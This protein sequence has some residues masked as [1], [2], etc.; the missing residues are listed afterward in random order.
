MNFLNFNF[1]THSE[2][3]AQEEKER[4][5]EWKNKRMKEWKHKYRNVKEG[6]TIRMLS[7]TFEKHN[8]ISQINWNFFLFLLLFLQL[9]EGMEF[10]DILFG[11]FGNYFY[12][13]YIFFTNLMYSIKY[14][15][16]GWE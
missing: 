3:K 11:Q 9:E 6:K 2:K 5:K 12:V 15:L 13:A 14:F 1:V 10:H 7:L 16:G 4:E 8:C